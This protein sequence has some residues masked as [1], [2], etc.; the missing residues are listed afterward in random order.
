[1]KKV[2]LLTTT[3]FANGSSLKM[4]NSEADGDVY[5]LHGHP[6][7][8]REGNTITISDCGYRTNVTKER[9]NGILSAFGQSESIYQRKGVWYIGDHEWHGS[10]Y[11][12]VE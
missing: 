1:M 11:F 4:G 2:T 10:T 6:I 3:A 9:L 7:A 12:F 8:R 5:L